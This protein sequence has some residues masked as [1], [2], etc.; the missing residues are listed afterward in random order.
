MI[1]SKHF[2]RNAGSWAA[3]SVGYNFQILLLTG[4][5]IRSAVPV[6]GRFFSIS[7]KKSL[8]IDQLTDPDRMKTYHRVLRLISGSTACI[9]HP[10]KY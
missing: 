8:Q 10:A 2:D 9:A 3:N 1:P 6:A 7:V 5:D 4:A